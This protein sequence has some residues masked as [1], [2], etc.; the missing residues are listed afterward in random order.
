VNGV[1][2]DSLAG[3][4]PGQV[5]GFT[6][7]GHLAAT[8]VTA[9]SPSP[10]AALPMGQNPLQIATLCW[11]TD[12]RQITVPI[13]GAAQA[14]KV[15][16]DGPTL[17]ITDPG[18]GNV[19]RVRANDGSNLGAFAAVPPGGSGPYAIAFDGVDI[20]T[21]ARSDDPFGLDPDV[22]IRLRG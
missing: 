17:W 7:S 1:P 2:V 11:W 10:A 5:L 21:A 20:W 9:P 14:V 18:R 16:C 8:T 4:Q 15:I 3:A 12:R 22:A 19:I 6:S 13:P